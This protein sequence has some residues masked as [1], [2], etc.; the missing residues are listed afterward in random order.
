VRGWTLSDDPVIPPRPRGWPRVKAAFSAPTGGQ[1]SPLRLDA[2]TVGAVLALQG[3]VANELIRRGLIR[4]TN[5]VGDWA[6]RLVEIALG[7]QLEPPS[8]AAFDLTYPASTEGSAPIRV[9]VKSRLVRDSSNKGQIQVGS[10]KHADDAYDELVIV[11]L[12]A[13]LWPVVGVRLPSASVPVSRPLYADDQF[14]Y[15]EEHE[16]ITTKLQAAFA[17]MTA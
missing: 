14:L 3:A 9:Q 17:S 5:V 8:N 15:R 16:D 10:V 2:V 1:Q 4:T 12:G 7:G 6:E 11:L 13:G